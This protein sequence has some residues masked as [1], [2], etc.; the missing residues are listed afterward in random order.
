MGSPRLRAPRRVA[1][2]ALALAV[3]SASAQ[4]NLEPTLP[5]LPGLSAPGG[6]APTVTVPVTDPS[7][8]HTDGPAAP[9]PKPPGNVKGL[10]LSGRVDGGTPRTLPLGAPRVGKQNGYTRVVLTL[11][12]GAAYRVTPDGRDLHVDLT[13][14]TADTLSGATNTDELRAWRLTPTP[15]GARLTLT[16]PGV[17]ARSGWH[18]LLLPEDGGQSARLVTDVSPAF[19]D[20]RPLTPA[21]RIITP[22]PAPAPGDTPADRTV[23]LDPGHGGKYPGA[24]GAVTEKAVT[25]DIALR[26]RAL[27][28]A[29]GVG[30]LMTRETDTHLFSSLNADLNARPALATNQARLFVSIH[31]NA[32]PAASVN[33]GFGVETWWNPNHTGSPALAQALQANIIRMTGTYSRGLKNTQSLAVL[34]GSQVPA[35]LIEVGF[36]SHPV[37]GDN[38]KDDLYL[39]R[40]AIG[41]A[42][43]IRDTLAAP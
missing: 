35:A 7:E 25:L 23:V 18:N 37:D 2:T 1:C 13:G 15:G 31:A 5:L 42:Q 26:V 14:V 6:A 9:P 29:A 17:T 33:K 36:V 41:I 30:V 8:D 4:L 21:E 10:S 27:L 11:P 40:L 43:G 38:L 32:M 20:T 39:D 34:R 22:L 3:Q 24:I 28:R 19:F 12:A 16:T